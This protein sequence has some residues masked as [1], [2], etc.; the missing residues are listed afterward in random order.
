MKWVLKLF[1]AAIYLC[2]IS[3]SE[4]RQLQ[5]NFLS[6][7]GYF[8]VERFPTGNEASIVGFSNRGIEHTL[9]FPMND[10]W[11]SVIRVAKKIENLSRQ[12]AYGSTLA[13]TRP[14]V[15]VDKENF[16]IQNGKVEDAGDFGH[17]RYIGYDSDGNGWADEIIIRLTLI[18][19]NQTKVVVERKVYEGEPVKINSS[20]VSL[21]DKLVPKNSSGNYERWVITQIDDDLNGNIKRETIAVKQLKKISHPT[22]DFSFGLNLQQTESQFNI[23]KINSSFTINGHKYSDK[24]LLKKIFVNTNIESVNNLDFVL[25]KF[26]DSFDKDLIK[27]LG[28]KGI[29]ILKQFN[30][31]EHMNY[32]DKDKVLLVL[33]ESID[34]NISETF[35]PNKTK[36]EIKSGTVQDT[37]LPTRMFGMIKIDGN[38]Q[39]VLYEPFSLEKM[40]TNAFVLE[41]Y[42]DDFSISFNIDQDEYYGED[43]SEDNII[44]GEDYRAH[45]LS[46][47]FF[48]SYPKLFEK[49]SDAV[50]IMEIKEAMDVAKK[51][52]EKKQY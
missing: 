31:L 40:W 41:A 27:I 3:C 17:T 28:G 22:I 30:S 26:T 48:K 46:D 10:V 1:V 39:L 12:K 21:K 13:S 7:G 4:I 20:G 8:R 34:L 36:P 43:I 52:R 11:K 45:K 25:T 47:S 50:N 32:T 29:D 23:S 19:D 49:I 18:S 15:L 24:S 33:A 2:C 42:A 14:I 6:T 9:N 35:N 38:V 16:V 51:L 37:L 5:N 44:F